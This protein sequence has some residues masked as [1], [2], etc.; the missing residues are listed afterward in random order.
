MNLAKSEQAILNGIYAAVAWLFLDFGLLFQEHGEQTLSVLS[1]RPEMAAG[2]VI[3]IACI[4]GL[5]YKSRLAAAV[6]FLLFII[7]LLLRLLQGAFPSTMLLLFSLVLLYFFLTA[8]LG[9]FSYQQLL[10][11]DQSS[12]QPD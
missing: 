12:D 10:T 7:P 3:V 8:V 9:T 6:L 1:S 11:Q 2:A 5:F 4:V